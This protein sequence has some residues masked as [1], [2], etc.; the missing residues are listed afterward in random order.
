MIRRFTLLVCLLA[1]PAVAAADVIRG[2]WHISP[3]KSVAPQAPG[4]IHLELS[5]K[6]N[7]H[8]NTMDVSEFRGLD[9]INSSTAG[10]VPAHFQLVREAG[11]FDF[12]GTFQSGDGV[13]R[14]TFTPDPSY[15]SRLRGLGITAEEMSDDK[16]FSLAILNVSS[17]FIGEM[18][19]LG[20]NESLSR[21][22]AF[23]IHGATPE[24]VRSLQTLGYRN[25]PSDDLVAFRIHGVTPEF[26]RGMQ[27]HGFN[28]VSGDRLVSFRIHGVTPEYVREMKAA[29]FFDGTDAERLV[30]FRIHGVTPE[31]ARDM[32]ELSV[33]NLSA[34][35]LVA[36]RIH[37][38]SSD[39][40]RQLAELGYRN[41]SS[42]Q[43]VSMRIHGVSIKFIK[44]LAEAVYRAVPV[45][46]LVQMKIHGIDDTF[47]RKVK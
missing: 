10:E 16:L 22:T 36:M 38:V 13:G 8:G 31:F 42:D 6:N 35:K 43:L 18:R 33:S 4:R 45:D 44:E 3:Q 32:R 46:K 11:T 21:Y 5:R 37:G 15:A 30:S 7:H 20:Y 39:Y 26:I 2:A 14:F 9:A 24:F 12:T 23:R 25:V 29:G 40:V 17:E 19:A 47:V 41:L 34:A 28:D 1:L 27:A